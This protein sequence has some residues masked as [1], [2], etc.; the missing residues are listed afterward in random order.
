MPLLKEGGAEWYLG[1]KH[2][3]QGSDRESIIGAQ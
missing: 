3:D 2:P 1:W